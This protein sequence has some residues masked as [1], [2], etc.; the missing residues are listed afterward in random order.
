[1]GGSGSSAE[2]AVAVD[3]ILDAWFYGV[4]GWTGAADGGRDEEETAGRVGSEGE[5]EGGEGAGGG[6]GVEVVDAGCE[7]L[8]LVCL[9]ELNS[10]S[11]EHLFRHSVLLCR[12]SG[13][14]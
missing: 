11:R 2:E 1:M 10:K 14:A 4:C 5:G 12:H 6:G 3:G 8:R 7:D 9:G 13:F